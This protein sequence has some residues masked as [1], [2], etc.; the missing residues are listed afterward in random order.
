MLILT[1]HG[2]GL[3]NYGEPCLAFESQKGNKSRLNQDTFKYQFRYVTLLPDEFAGRWPWS[4]R[5][6]KNAL[7]LSRTNR[8]RRMRF[9]YGEKPKLNRKRSKKK[10]ERITK[11]KIE[12]KMTLRHTTALY[13]NEISTA[14]TQI[15]AVHSIIDS[16]ET[17]GYNDSCIM[18]LGTYQIVI[19]RSLL[20]RQV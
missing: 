3:D 19:L 17:K 10:A 13:S 16:F 9:V 6:V 8:A 2:E 12:S 5:Y 1:Q 14:Y 15:S 11:I 7:K 18:N 4:L 20:R